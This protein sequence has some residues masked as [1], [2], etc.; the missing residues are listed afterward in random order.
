MKTIKI[1]LIIALGTLLFSSCKSSDDNSGGTTTEN[2]YSAC[3]KWIAQTMREHYLWNKEIPSDSKLDYTASPE[4]FFYTLLSKSDGKDY[5]KGANHYYYSY[6]E[7]NKDYKATTKSISD[8]TDS[9]GID[10]ARYSVT[11][12]TYEYDRV[13]YVLPNSPAAKSGLV[14]GDWIIKIDGN[15]IYSSS[16]PADYTK[17]ISGAQRT[18]TV[19]HSLADKSSATITLQA[20]GAVNS[21]PVFYSSVIDVNGKKVGYL[22]YNQFATGPHDDYTNH[23]YDKELIDLFNNKFKGVDE[24]ILDLRYNPGGYL[25][26]AALLSRLLV[27]SG[28]SSSI[29]C[30]L[31]DTDNKITEDKF[32]DVDSSKDYNLNGFTSLNLSRIFIIATGSTASASEAVINGLAPYLP[33]AKIGETTEGKNVGSVNYDGDDKYAWDIQPITFRITSSAGNDYSTGLTPDYVLNELDPDKN[34]NFL[35]FG[36]VN[37]YLLSKALSL[38]SGTVSAS[39]TVTRKVAESNI[40][41]TPF[42]TTVSLHKVRGLIRTTE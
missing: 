22:V 3:N 8:D 32:N 14:R 30:K 27:P 11:N 1:Y 19:Y 21:D 34:S 13:M 17:L 20:S 7:N 33:E 6:I 28:S 25:S 2:A 5:N 37:E 40:K 15:Y 26:S 36:D 24:F 41:V 4:T 31:T 35:N 42:A 29:F 18:L 23:T 16:S 10:L 12:Q 38:I 9:Y 39:S